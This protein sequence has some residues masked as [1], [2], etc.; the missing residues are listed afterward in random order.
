MSVTRLSA[1]TTTVS[2]LTTYIKGGAFAILS[3][4]AITRP[5]SSIF[6]PAV[7]RSASVCYCCCAQAT[8]GVDLKMLERLVFEV[9]SGGCVII[10]R[11]RRV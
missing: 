7:A 3:P 10:G 2:A 6:P 1:K 8:E 9:S 11:Q 4:I 5:L